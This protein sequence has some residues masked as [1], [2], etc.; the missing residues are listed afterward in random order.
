MMSKKF[1]W[2]HLGYLG[3]FHCLMVFGTK[4]P[5]TWH[6]TINLFN[7]SP[8]TGQKTMLTFYR[9]F[10][11]SDLDFRDIWHWPFGIIGW[12][13]KWPPFYHNLILTPKYLYVRPLPR[14]WL[15]YNKRIKGGKMWDD[16][17]FKLWG[18][19]LNGEERRLMSN[20]KFYKMKK[21]IE[22]ND[23]HINSMSNDTNDSVRLYGGRNKLQVN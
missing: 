4:N 10:C 20:L 19:F 15:G 2:T 1:E 13:S 18:K 21:Y 12:F 3:H 14:R 23:W 16:Y 17:Y 5:H 7:M 6:G 22:N 11:N 9:P 8:Q